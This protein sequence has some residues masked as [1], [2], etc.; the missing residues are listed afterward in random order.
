MKSPL[1]ISIFFLMLHQQLDQ[2]I[3]NS[4]SWYPFE[5]SSKTT[6]NLPHELSWWP[7]QKLDENEL[8][9][10]LEMD[11]KLWCHEPPKEATTCFSVV[12]VAVVL[13]IS[14][15][16]SKVSFKDSLMVVVVQ[17]SKSLIRNWDN[18]S[19]HL[20]YTNKIQ[21]THDRARKKTTLWR[22]HARVSN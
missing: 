6:T 9:R 12:Q 1:N 15:K 18:F 14:H 16:Q 4:S 5:S 21:E 3:L 19:L 11:C 22:R 20:G 17:I 8:T 13:Y 2:L 7:N 10:G